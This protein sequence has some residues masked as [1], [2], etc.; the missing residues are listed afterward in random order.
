MSTGDSPVLSTCAPMPQIKPCPP[1]RAARI[2]AATA[3]RSAPPRMD[4]SD[5]TSRAPAASLNGV[6]K[7][8]A[9]TL[10]FREA[11][12]YVLTADR[13]NSSYG[14]FTPGLYLGDSTHRP[15]SIAHRP[16]AIAHR[17]RTSH[18]P[19]PYTTSIASP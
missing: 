10:L 4:G 13:S 3:F 7:S 2:A 9:F 8:A 17:H 19:P 12:G 1:S 11:S 18:L 5:L 15:S 16:S 6:A 14:N